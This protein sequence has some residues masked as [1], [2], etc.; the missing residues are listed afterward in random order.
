MALHRKSMKSALLVAAFLMIASCDQA[1]I[2]S[3]PGGVSRSDA[4]A[5]DEAAKKLD[6][7]QTNPGQDY[8]KDRPEAK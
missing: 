8:A 2:D 1:G 4:K 6:E 5:L 7:R 3:G